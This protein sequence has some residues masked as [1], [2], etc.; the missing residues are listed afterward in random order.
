[1]IAALIDPAA[2]ASDKR[3]LTIAAV[4]AVLMEIG[5][6]AWVLRDAVRDLR[7]ERPKPRA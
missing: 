4:G 3:W 6:M 5:F 1:M 7:T 2:R